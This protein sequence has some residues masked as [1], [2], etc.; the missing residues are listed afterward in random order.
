M[1]RPDPREF[2]LFGSTRDGGRFYVCQPG[3]G[4]NRWVAYDVEAGGRLANP[5]V[6]FGAV[7]E[8]GWRG[9]PAV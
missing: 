9:L 3:D 8:V 1:S 5:R 6:I 7:E 4:R 2:L